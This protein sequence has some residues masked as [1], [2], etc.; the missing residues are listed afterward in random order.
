MWIG[1]NVHI[2]HVFCVFLSRSVIAVT[3]SMVTD[4]CSTKAKTEACDN[5]KT[6]Y[7]QTYELSMGI[8]SRVNILHFILSL[9]EIRIVVTMVTL[10]KCFSYDN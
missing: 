3:M 6:N 7:N 10:K 9:S 5:I 4:M 2:M 1:E 8:G